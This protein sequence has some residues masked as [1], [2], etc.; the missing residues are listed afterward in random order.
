MT[1]REKIVRWL[2][3]VAPTSDTYSEEL[4]LLAAALC[5]ERG[6]HLARPEPTIPYAQWKDEPSVG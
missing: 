5:I 2:R 4:A 6:D 3:R 1:D